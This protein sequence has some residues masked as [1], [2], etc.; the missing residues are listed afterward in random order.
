MKFAIICFVAGS[1]AIT[2]RDP[3]EETLVQTEG[4]KWTNWPNT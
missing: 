3:T 2:V 4:D 1:S